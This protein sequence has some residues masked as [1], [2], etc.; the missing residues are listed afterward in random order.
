MDE[1]HLLAAVHHVVTNPV[2]AGLVPTAA[3]WRWSSAQAHLTHESDG[4]VDPR[5]TR[6]AVTRYS[7]HSVC[8]IAQLVDGSLARFR[9][10][11]DMNW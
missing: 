4:L 9:I 10:F 5:V 6:V 2:E 3:D 7:G 11:L 8:H 1:A